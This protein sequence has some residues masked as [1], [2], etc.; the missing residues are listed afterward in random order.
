MTPELLQKLYDAGFTFPHNVSSLGQHCERCGR[1]WT[2]ISERPCDVTEGELIHDI[3]NVMGWKEHFAL[4]HEREK[5]VWGW[6]AMIYFRGEA[7]WESIQG[8]GETALIALAN[9]RIKLH[10]LGRLV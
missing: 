6:V 5:G 10:E 1:H 7:K 8:K 3:T 4:N 9:L 2:D